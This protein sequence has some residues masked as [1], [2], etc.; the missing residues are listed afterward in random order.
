MAAGSEKQRTYSSSASGANASGSAAQRRSFSRT[1][2]AGSAPISF[3][4]SPSG[5][6]RNSQW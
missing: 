2:Q 4:G 5:W 3:S 1:H 6:A